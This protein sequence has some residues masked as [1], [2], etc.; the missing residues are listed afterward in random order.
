M[1]LPK[2]SYISFG[3]EDEIKVVLFK[4][5]TI[6]KAPTE[7]ITHARQINDKKGVTV[8]SITITNITITET[9]INATII[10]I[11]ENSDFISIANS[12]T[13]V[14]E[15]KLGGKWVVIV[16]NNNDVSD[17][18]LK[19][20][21]LIILTIIDL[22]VIIYNKTDCFEKF[23]DCSH[24]EEWSS[25]KIFTDIRNNNHQVIAIPR[26]ND[27]KTGTW[28]K[29]VEICHKYNA[30]LISIESKEKQLFLE[31]FEQ[32]KNAFWTSGHRDSNGKWKWINGNEIS[33]TN[34]GPYD[35]NNAGGIENCIAVWRTQSNENINWM[36]NPNYNWKWLDIQCDYILFIVCEFS[37]NI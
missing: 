4:L 20:D 6:I 22:K 24:S 31:S 29:A 33:Y 32:L 9:I 23:T 12:I 26:K 14:C 3:I 35:P 13:Q 10:A 17:Q 18:I 5:E 21:H 16:G 11:H 2:T 30:S 25:C 15:S 37:F 34:W 19:K 7:I 28:E 8:A 36:T 1:D 27:E